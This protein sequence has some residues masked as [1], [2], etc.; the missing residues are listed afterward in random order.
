MSWL[1][2]LTF[3]R[4]GVLNW[5]KIPISLIDPS[6][7]LRVQSF[8]L[9]CLRTSLKYGPYDDVLGSSETFTTVG[10]RTQRLTRMWPRD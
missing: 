10:F 6:L 4:E 7:R 8:H 3:V 2:S 9:R 5:R 1:R